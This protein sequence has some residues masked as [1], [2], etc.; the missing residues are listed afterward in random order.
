M[1]RLGELDLPDRLAPLLP[2]WATQI[3]VGLTCTGIGW[4]LRSLLDTVTAG[5]RRSPWSI[6]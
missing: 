5:R 1:A 3:A 6:R 4:V 2:R